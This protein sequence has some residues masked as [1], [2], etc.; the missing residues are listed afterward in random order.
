MKKLCIPEPPAAARHRAL[1]A[2]GKPLRRSGSKVRQTL[3]ILAGLALL[4]TAV[5]AQEFKQH[6]SREFSIGNAAAG[7]LTLYNING[8][9]RVEG[10]SGDKVVVG[11]DE[12]ITADDSGEVAVGKNEVKPEF[13][14]RGDSIL[15]YLSAPW[16][17]RPH[18][19]DRNGQWNNERIDY[20]FQLSFTV[21]V[22]DKMNVLVST[23]NKG[24]VVVQDVAGALNI[25][26][27]NGPITI[28]NAKGATKAR[29]INGDLTVGYQDTPPAASDYY[30]LNGT[31]TVTY[32]ANMS[33]I[34]QFKSMNGSFYTDFPNVEV[35][36]AKVIRNEERTGNGVRY[37]LN[38]ARQVK[39]GDGGK[40]F[41]F[42]TMNGDIYIKKQS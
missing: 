8:P 24:D 16:D 42:E 11:V 2:T 20:D 10:Y 18:R 29:T 27:V 28:R 17:S 25:N 40:L 22:P 13:E 38:I 19:W 4:C 9:I 14:Q 31:L 35:L 30:T 6:L 7:Q 1:P 39:I 34:C 23:V 32:P 37:K 15:I 12:L 26:N 36:P 21:K 3:A 41:K 33:A 5:Q